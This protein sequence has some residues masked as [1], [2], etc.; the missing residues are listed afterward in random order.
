MRYIY[1]EPIVTTISDDDLNDEKE[2][3]TLLLRLKELQHGVYME[4][5]DVENLDYR[6]M[7][8]NVRI[9]DVRDNDCDIHAFYPNASAR[10]RKVPFLNIHKIRLLA[11]KQVVSQK[12][13]VTRWHL[14]D[15]AEIDNA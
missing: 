14:M 10:Y 4:F 8:N 2:I 3:K 13:K 1:Q 5:E 11:N 9:T 15:V 12:Y 7:C 6:R